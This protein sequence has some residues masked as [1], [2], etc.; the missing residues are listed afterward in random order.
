MLQ[1]PGLDSRLQCAVFPGMLILKLS[2]VDP[3]PF[4][5]EGPK[6]AR[7]PWELGAGGRE[8]PVCEPGSW[9]PLL[10]GSFSARPCAGCPGPSLPVRR[11]MQVLGISTLGP[12]AGAASCLLPVLSLWIFGILGSSEMAALRGGGFGVCPRATL[13][14]G[15]LEQL[16]EILDEAEPRGKDCLLVPL[17]QGPSLC[18]KLDPLPFDR[19]C[20]WPGPGAGEAPSLTGT[21]AEQAGVWRGADPAWPLSP[22][23]CGLS[24]VSLLD[25]LPEGAAPVCR[26]SRGLDLSPPLDTPTKFR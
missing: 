19:F 10:L 6:E 18:R 25:G 15:A 3:R 26:P 1:K 23:P 5:L 22:K 17:N 12:G 4:P 21:P 7:L 9:G 8:L 13:P 2:K 24:P 14:D 16:L 11:L 20:A